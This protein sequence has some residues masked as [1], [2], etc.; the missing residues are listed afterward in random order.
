M[1]LNLKFG[2][3]GERA[4]LQYIK[5][6][7]ADFSATIIETDY[8]DKVRLT[9]EEIASFIGATPVITI[10]S[11]ESHLRKIRKNDIFLALSELVFN[12][13]YLSL[14]VRFNPS[15]RKVLNEFD[16]VYLFS[17]GY[18]SLFS[19]KNRPLIIGSTHG[20]SVRGRL[21]S[22]ELFF[23]VMLKLIKNNLIFRR[24]DGFHVLRPFY[25]Q[26][27]L[28]NRKFDFLLPNGVDTKVFAPN[29]ELKHDNVRINFIFV[30]RL[31]KSKGIDLL[32]NGWKI[33]L[34]KVNRPEYYTLHIVGTGSAE[35]SLEGL[36]NTI[37]HGVVHTME[38]A[39]LYKESDIFLFPSTGEIYPMVI[40]EA[41]ASG[42]YVLC[43][44]AVNGVF[45]QFVELGS[46]KYIQM[47]P[48]GFAEDMLQAISLAPSIRAIT[49]KTVD[50]IKKQF[51]WKLITSILYDEIKNAV[52]ERKLR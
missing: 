34:S 41:L 24:I 48:Y 35:T 15:L 11:L 29:P 49:T 44:S 9:N 21:K 4:L 52:T 30:G 6:L 38:L 10:S 47:E 16:V 28:F 40:L 3:G 23:K 50:T 2:G 46:L 26:N 37:L 8:W 7:P 39:N 42:L 14:Y 22:L 1:N 51:D 27:D 17:N 5:N 31:E 25:Q 36:S 18:A 45:H 12:P 13:L 20:M 32:I 43:S 33:F 19:F